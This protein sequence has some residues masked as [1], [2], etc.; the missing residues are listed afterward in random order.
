LNAAEV[1]PLQVDC[2]YIR[3]NFSLEI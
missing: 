2:D 3:R 1:E